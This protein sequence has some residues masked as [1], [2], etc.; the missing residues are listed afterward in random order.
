MTKKDKRALYNWRSFSVYLPPDLA[1]KVIADAEA[2]Q[3]KRS[4]FL[5]RII[6][7]YYREQEAEA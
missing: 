5:Y 1:K 2:E 4:N 3:R 7:R 6:A